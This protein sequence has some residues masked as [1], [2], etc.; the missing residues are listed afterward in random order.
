[1]LATIVSGFSVTLA[2]GH[3]VR[4]VLH[5]TLRPDDGLPMILGRRQ[6]RRSN[7]LNGV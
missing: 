3:V 1:V 7:S 4:P 5:V 6:R 2:P